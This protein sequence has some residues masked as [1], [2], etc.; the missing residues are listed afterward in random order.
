MRTTVLKL[1]F[2]LSVAPSLSAEI[3]NCKKIENGE[4]VFS[5][6]TE[7]L[8]GLISLAA[9]KLATTCHSDG[10]KAWRCYAESERDPLHSFEVFVS[11]SARFI[12]YYG[13]NLWAYPLTCEV[14]L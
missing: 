14:A 2:M 5:M 4:A 3:I 10:R 12:E 1:L 9:T 13:R 7:N 8:S 11:E 6:N